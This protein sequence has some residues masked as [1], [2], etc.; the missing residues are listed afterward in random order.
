MHA[1]RKTLPGNIVELL[2]SGSFE[3]I[4]TVLDRCAVGAYLRIFNNPQLL[5]LNECSDEVVRWAV[6][7]GE[8]INAGD[9]YGNTPLHERACENVAQIPLFLSLGAEV[10]ARNKNGETPLMYA[11]LYHRSNSLQILLQ[12][13]ADPNAIDAPRWD[14][15]NP[16]DALSLL[17]KRATWSDL[18]SIV[19]MVEQLLAAGAI[20]KTTAHEPL[21][22]FGEEFEFCAANVTDWN[23]EDSKPSDTPE[24]YR[25]QLNWLYHVFG[26]SPVPSIHRHDGMTQIVIPSGT[27][28]QQYQTLWNTLVPA[29][30]SADTV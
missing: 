5:H 7:R 1:L 30:G 23:G 13:G 11:A 8:D 6:A 16:K 19:S 2:K 27:W 3:Q 26:V 12:A 15:E 24:Q 14:S 25:S 4:T 20:P 17:F 9:Y 10:D 22:L 28:Q 21:R 29:S 18:P